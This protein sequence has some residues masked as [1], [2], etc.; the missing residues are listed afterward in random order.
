[1]RSFL[2]PIILLFVIHPTARDEDASTGNSTFVAA[3]FSSE[4]ISSG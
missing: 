3:N 4:A 1:M 2:L